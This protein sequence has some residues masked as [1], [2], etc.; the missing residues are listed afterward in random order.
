MDRNT[1]SLTSHKHH[2]EF[3]LTMIFRAYGLLLCNTRKLH[4]LLLKIGRK[5]ML[6]KH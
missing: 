5:L 4:K 3:Y 6:L 1:Q 2:D